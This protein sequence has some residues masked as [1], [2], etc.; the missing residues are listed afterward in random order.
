MTG[1]VLCRFQRVET[2]ADALTF[3]LMKG[4]ILRAQ[5][6]FALPITGN[7]TRHGNPSATFT[8]KLNPGPST[9]ASKSGP[10][11][12]AN[13]PNVLQSSRCSEAPVK[14]V[15]GHTKTNNILSPGK[16]MFL[17]LTPVKLTL[18]HS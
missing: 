1:Q 15:T 9:I 16:S 12:I 4:Q 17:L 10:S 14:S 8:N 6:L 5:D 18:Q 3:M 13:K 11:I 7:P 2:F